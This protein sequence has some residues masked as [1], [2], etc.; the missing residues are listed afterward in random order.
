MPR[1]YARI[2]LSIADDD[3]FE[4][5]SPQA[6]WLY[7]RVLIPDPTLNYAG[8]ADWR[9]KRL[10]RKA[11]CLTLEYLLAAAQELEERR[12]CLFDL[13]TEEVLVRSYIRNDEILRNPK[14]A[15]AMVKAYRG[16]ASKPLQAAIVDEVKRVRKESPDYSSWDS[17][18]VGKDLSEILS[19]P[20]LDEVGYTNAI[21]VPIGN[22][23][24]VPITNRD[25]G[26]DYQ[27]DSVPIPSNSNSTSTP[28]NMGGSVT[29]VR[30]QTT[31]PPTPTRPHCRR[32]P[33]EN[34]KAENCYACGQRREWDEAERKR[35]EADELESRR[36]QKLVAAQR[37]K[38]CRQCD[39][40][41]WRY[42]DRAIK[43]DHQEAVNA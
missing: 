33:I 30:H 41:G 11:G 9:P 37:L 14:M 42:D 32:H 25:P 26:A 19:K 23:D 34:A 18:T 3:D 27:S 4:S 8:V 13:D 20:G 6:Q 16:T 10:L 35:R 1:E 22:A 28:F 39:E 31:E 40:D 43:C 36:Q 5:L 21:S 2:R 17:S 15:A 38:A 29:G 24:G 7:L 12:Y